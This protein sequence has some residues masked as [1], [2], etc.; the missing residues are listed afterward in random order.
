MIQRD[1]Y[2]RVCDENKQ[3]K[4]Q[5][6]KILE[7]GRQAPLSSGLIRETGIVR[8]TARTSDRNR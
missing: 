6:K 8:A 5:L 2:Q 3:L 1:E 7:E 4:A